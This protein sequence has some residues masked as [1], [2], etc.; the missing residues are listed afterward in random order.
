MKP[1]NKGSSIIILDQEQYLWEGSKQLNDPKY[2]RKL[3][4][5]IYLDTV[6]M[7]K[8]ITQIL[9]VKKYINALSLT[10]NFFYKSKARHLARRFPQP[11]P[12]FL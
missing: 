7:V 3:D 6:P 8:D 1:A 12:T 2:Y 4:K 11:T 9:Y 5:P 10:G